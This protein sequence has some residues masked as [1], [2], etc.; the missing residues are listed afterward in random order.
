V[1][2]WSASLR[3]WGCWAAEIEAIGKQLARSKVKML[4]ELR[5]MLAL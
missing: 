5:D 2:D 3:G 1:G 4:V